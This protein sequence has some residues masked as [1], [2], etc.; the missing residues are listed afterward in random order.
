MPGRRR[1]FQSRRPIDRSRGRAHPLSLMRYL[2]SILVRSGAVILLV[3]SGLAGAQAAA[4]GMGHSAHCAEPVTIA[5]P[6]AE[7]DPAGT[8]AHGHGSDD[9]ASHDGAHGPCT[10]HQCAGPLLVAAEIGGAYRLARVPAARAADLIPAVFRP[11]AL[12]RPP[13]A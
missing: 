7:A 6:S 2:A 10:V 9:E 13:Q 4:Q 3:L 11:E 1:T 5:A 12:Q 8:H